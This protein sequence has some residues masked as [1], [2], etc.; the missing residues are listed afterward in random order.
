MADILH[1]I[2]PS[3]AVMINWL[4]SASWYVNS[5]NM[6]TR[7]IDL[8]WG[9]QVNIP[10]FFLRNV[11]RLE[12]GLWSDGKSRSRKCSPWLLRRVLASGNEITTDEICSAPGSNVCMAVRSAHLINVFNAASGFICHRW[13][14]KYQER[15][16]PYDIFEKNSSAFD[17]KIKSTMNREIRC[18]YFG[19]SEILKNIWLRIWEDFV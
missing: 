11:F 13:K 8:I 19:F 10:S 3:V 14:R 5:V 17:W 12:V 7:P 6:E 1:A 16:C 18:W 9:S 2:I 15:K 4:S